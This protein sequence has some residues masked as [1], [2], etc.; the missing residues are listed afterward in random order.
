[1]NSS[2]LPGSIIGRYEIRSQLGEGGMGEVYLARDSQ[3][4]RL[5]AIKVLPSLVARDQQRLHRFLQ[6]A[7]AASALNH[8][9]AAHI[10]EIGEAETNTGKIHF[11]AMEYVE[12]QPLDAL[13]GGRP[14][15]NPQLVDIAT[16]IAT[17]LMKPTEKELLIAILSRQTSWSRHAGA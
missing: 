6:E 2:F 11:I 5:V 14:M 7:R 3:L 10:Y 8:P 15:A 16:Q 9:N 13:I 4:D 1:M 12:E 17:H